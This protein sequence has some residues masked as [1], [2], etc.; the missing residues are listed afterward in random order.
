MKKFLAG[1]WFVLLIA[2]LLAATAALSAYRGIQVREGREKI[3]A[4]SEALSASEDE[5]A[6]LRAIR[7]AD[8]KA[9]EVRTE[10]IKVVEAKEAKRNEAIDK[11]VQA[12]PSW[13]NQPV[14]ADIADSLRR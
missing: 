12:N 2:L 14:P 3:E 11:A 9:I 6:K 5:N 7:Q 8:T 13:A 4:L 1:N 10:T